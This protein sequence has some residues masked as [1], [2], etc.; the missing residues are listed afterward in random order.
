MFWKG[1]NEMKFFS[2]N[3]ELQAMRIGLLLFAGGALGWGIYVALNL[4]TLSS[5]PIW[6]GNAAIVVYMMFFMVHTNE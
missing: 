3:K 1:G 4:K 2:E 6:I 5:I